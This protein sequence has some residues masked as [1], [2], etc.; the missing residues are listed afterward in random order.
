M[1]RIIRLCFIAIF[2]STFLFYSEFVL[3]CSVCIGD[4]N[5]SLS[6]GTRAGILIL[7]GIIF[8]ILTSIVG[9]TLFW[10]RRARSLQEG[11]D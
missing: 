6:Q 11:F 1:I 10:I 7:L 9:V 5:S 4:P 8:F 2:F 3:A